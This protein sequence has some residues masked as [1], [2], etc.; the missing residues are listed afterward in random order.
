MLKNEMN[1][2]GKASL[3]GCQFAL[4]GCSCMALSAFVLTNGF[5]LTNRA[6]AAPPPA[7]PTPPAAQ[8]PK[9]EPPKAE[10][11]KAEPPKAE[12]PKAEPKANPPTALPATAQPQKVIRIESTGRAIVYVKTDG[13]NRMGDAIVRDMSHQVDMR[14][15][16]SVASLRDLLEP[17]QKAKSVVATAAKTLKKARASLSDLEIDKGLSSAEQTVALLEQNVSALGPKGLRLLVKSLTTLALAQF[18]KG[19]K[20]KA[21]ESLSRAV[22]F[23]PSLNYNKKRFPPQMKEMFDGVHFLVSELGR[24]SA[25]IKTTPSGAQVYVNGKFVGLSPVTAKGLIVGKN[26]VTARL[27]GYKTQTLPLEVAGP[28]KPSEKTIALASIAGN[29]A[30]ILDAAL[31]AALE[32]QTVGAHKELATRYK[33]N[34]LILGKVASAAA[35]TL[36]VS[37]R[38]YDSGRKKVVGAAESEVK[39][40]ADSEIEAKKV[41]D[42]LFASAVVIKRPKPKPKPS[43]PGFFSRM[44]KSKYFWPVVG[45]VLG[46]MA[47]AGATVGIIAASGGSSNNNDRNR[48]VVGVLPAFRY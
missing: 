43:G 32:K 34:L 24:G 39:M 7:Q 35:G 15:K 23:D 1:N 46:A 11:P 36:K 41:V 48:L 20:S 17:N 6:T 31:T 44:V 12:P 21:S 27:L 45:G 9:A 47:I 40:P 28:S 2:R 26:Y 13:K 30:S 4:W 8:P 38:L 19:L 10:P 22:V 25:V 33:L 16:V 3:R 37:L 42:A 18:L 29:A 14:E 5:F